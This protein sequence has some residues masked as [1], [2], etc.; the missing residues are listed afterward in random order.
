M[1][2]SSVGEAVA[3][4]VTKP[5]GSTDV[6]AALMLADGTYSATKRYPSGSYT[7]KAHGNTVG[8]Y[9]SWDSNDV[10]FTVRTGTLRVSIG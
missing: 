4:T 10:V 1:S 9:S 8:S 3:I 6:L 7:A 5:D 2:P